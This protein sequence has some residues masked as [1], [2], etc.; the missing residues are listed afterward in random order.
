M[1]LLNKDS[2]VPLYIQFKEYLLERIE[3]GQLEPDQRLPSERQFCDQL[4]VSRI[5][6]RQAL[7]EL[8]RD[9]LIRSVPGKGTFVARKQ[10]GEFHPLASFSQSVQAQEQRPSSRVLNQ[11]LIHASKRLASVL[12]IPTDSEVVLIKR[13]RLVDDEPCALQAA[14]LPSDLCPNILKQDFAKDS[15]YTVLSDEYGLV[16]VKANNSF[17]ARLA[18]ADEREDL[19]LPQPSAVLVM[20]QTSYLHNSRPVEYTRSVYKGNQRFESIHGSLVSSQQD[21]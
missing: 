5:T 14:F 6:I 17:E 7:N 12:Q 4:D 13:L 11:A 18:D 15:L 19:L 21:L 3:S 8:M 10:E 9:G 20:R 16:P 2:P 1:T